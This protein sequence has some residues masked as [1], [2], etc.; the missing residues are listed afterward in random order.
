MSLVSKN[1]FIFFLAEFFPAVLSYIFLVIISNFSTTDAVGILGFIIT[2][3][4]LLANISNLEIHIGMK[5]YLGISISEN[6][7]SSFKQI[8]ISS[9][10]FVL[11]ISISILIILLNPFVNFLGYFG[12]NSDFVPIV[13]IIVV[14]SNLHRI[15]TGIFSSSLRTTSLI[16]P[17]LLASFLRFPPLLFFIYMD[18]LTEFTVS[19][20]Y[21][22]FYAMISI[23]LLISL[24][25]YFRRLDGKFF[26][27]MFLNVKLVIRG[28]L[29]RWISSIIGTIGTKLNILVIFSTHGAYESGLFFV[30]FVIFSAL[31]M[32][33]NAITQIMHPIFSGIKEDDKQLLL[34]QRTMKLG[35]LTTIPISS[36]IFFY[37]E[38]ILSIFDSKFVISGDLLGILL[39]SFPLMIFND[40][41]Y[42]LFYARGKYTYIF[43]IGLI[44]NIPRVL[45]YFIL[46]PEFENI[47]AAWAF[48][49]GTI[50]Q[51]L[52]TFFLI[53]KSNI[54]LQYFHYL[55]LTLIPFL[56]G[57]LINQIHI[58]LLG[59]CLVFIISYIVFFKLKLFDEDDME[60]YINFFSSK[61]QTIKRKNSIIKIL[62]Y[63]KL[64]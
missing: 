2:F 28:S 22:V 51:T 48:T 15:F 62:K 8:S 20:S 29:A 54:R 60:H 18:D 36:L 26:K 19:W 6:N 39:I 27:N 58:G 38:N 47:G 13:S 33:I 23:F 4:A 56:I 53:I 43:S 32:L 40:I 30:P 44:T 59:A 34:F 35:F 10:L 64:Y 9:T 21:S 24:S 12:L 57:F 7:W 42:Y 17:S 1:I 11:L 31:M 61:E 16:L 5:R 37:A 55:I 3:S 45:L 52:V 25:N 46:I 41:S 63:C 50:F 14:G 49:I